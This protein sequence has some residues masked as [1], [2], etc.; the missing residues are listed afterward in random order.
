MT[1]ASTVEGFK[2]SGVF[3]WDPTAIINKK[4]APLTMFE[5]QGE[6]LKVNTSIN[7]AGPET[8]E[9]PKEDDR[10]QNVT[11]IIVEVPAEEPKTKEQWVLP[12]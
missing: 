11:D 6:L 7:E 12:L 2:K 1:V 3:Q 4:L 8:R 10:R 9:K 5:K